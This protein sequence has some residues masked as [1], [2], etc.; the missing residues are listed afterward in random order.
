M[1]EAPYQSIADA[2]KSS[3]IATGRIRAW[4]KDGC[5]PYITSGNKYYVKMKGLYEYLE[6]LEDTIRIKRIK[7]NGVHK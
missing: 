3:G 4:V 2:S 1:N 5:I 6:A 7:N